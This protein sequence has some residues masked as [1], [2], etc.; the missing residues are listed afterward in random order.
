MLLE[1][2]PESKASFGFIQNFLG[3]IYANRGDYQKAFGFQERALKFW[4]QESSIQY[5][6]HHI[7]NTYVHLGVVY[8]HLG[9]LDLA[10]KHLLIAVELR[11][12]TTSLAFAYNEI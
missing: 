6:Q 4:T 8:H 5:N 9:Q 10:L 1:Y 12:P 7:A 3:I 11:S 2:T